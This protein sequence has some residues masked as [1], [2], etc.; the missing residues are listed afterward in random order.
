MTKGIPKN[1]K[2][3]YV[4][5][6]RKCGKPTCCCNTGERHGPYVY[7]EWRENGKVRTTY[8]SKAIKEK[9]KDEEQGKQPEQ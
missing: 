6:Y 8:V 1:R 9:N 2:I 4:T 3:S 5:Q 7:A